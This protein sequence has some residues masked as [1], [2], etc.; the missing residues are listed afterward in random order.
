LTK[1][2]KNIH[3]ARMAAIYNDARAIVA[4]GKCPLCGAGIRR[5]LSMAGWWQCDQFGAEMF[6]RD[7]QKPP[8]NWQIFTE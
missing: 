6:R 7:P 4:T 1:K 8:C 2:E 3:R 5:N